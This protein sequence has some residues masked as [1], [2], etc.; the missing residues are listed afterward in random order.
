MKLLNCFS[1]G[2]VFALHYSLRECSCKKV[3]GQYRK[4]GLHADV[5][6]PDRKS[7]AVL[8]FANRSFQRALIDQAAFGDSEELMYYGG[9]M[10]PSGRTFN[11]FIIPEAADTVHRHYSE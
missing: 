6:M 2:D 1:C 3:S 5:Y 8:G 10:T 9:K 4:D 11:A 7:G